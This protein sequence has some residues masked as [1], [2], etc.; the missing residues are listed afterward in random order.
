MCLIVSQ[1]RQSACWLW[2]V[3]ERPT[4]K[5]SESAWVVATACQ[6]KLSEKCCVFT[7]SFSKSDVK[8]QEIADNWLKLCSIVKT[9]L[10]CGRQNI[11]LCGH[12]DSSC[13]VGRDPTA[14]HRNLWALLEFSVSAGDTVLQE[15]LA[16]ASA[17]CQI[18]VT[19]NPKWNSRYFW[20]P[21]WG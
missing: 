9:V 5:L 14:S 4:H 19:Y 7:G 11:S 6:Q 15:H 12:G 3:S 18:H 21:G 2:C 10:L 17:I 1:E 13:D 20:C 8:W 16:K